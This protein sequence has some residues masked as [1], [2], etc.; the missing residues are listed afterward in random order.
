MGV[1][2]PA[3]AATPSAFD[4]YWYRSANEVGTVFG[5]VSPDSAMTLPAFY[6]AVSYVSE[7]IAK[8]PLSMYEDIGQKGSR[9]ARDHEIQELLHNQPN[10]RQTAIEWRENV[11]AIAMLRGS[12]IN[13]I[14]YGPSASFRGTPT[15]PGRI[16]EIVPLHPDLVRQEPLADGS[17]RYQYRDPLRNGKE[18][19][20]L[21][22]DTFIIRGRQSRGVLEYAA[23]N[24]G[25]EL[26]K[27][28][29]AGLMF[30]RGAKHSGVIEAKGKIVDTVRAGLRVALDEY[31]IGGPR[32]GRPL[33]LE[34]GMSWKDITM[35]AQQSDLLAMQQFSVSQVCRWI[36]VPPHK[37]FDLTRSTNNN[38]ETQGVDYVTD[39]LLAWAVRFEQAIWRDLVTD[40][41]FFAK[42]TLDGLLRGDFETRSKGYA[43]AIMWGWMTRNEVRAK[44]DYNPIEGL[45]EPLTPVNMTTDPNGGAA[46]VQFASQSVPLQLTASESGR[47]QLI[48]SDAA[49]RV[50]RRE[51][52]AMSKL[53]ERAA[54]DAE[55]WRS[56]VEAFYADHGPEVARQLHIPDHQAVAY[57]REQRAALIAGGLSAMDDWLV[58]R[59]G[60]LASLACDSNLPLPI[61]A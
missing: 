44:E 55:A 53:A 46:S 60:H 21:E 27:E 39:C 6:A 41:R 30:A 2:G 40:K 13:E 31:A 15:R 48:A 5:P 16:G 26:A 18:R 47:L 56:G 28:R 24:I 19:A 54:G 35:T 45:D 52:A 8:I 10:R 42:H 37:V 38:I 51:L 1:L 43:L 33:L 58:E 7:D 59:A 12:G 32:A 9:P 25:T 3:L 4:D 57:A 61:A 14:R 11:A 50:V 22:E 20:I 49:S 34:D 29:H 23:S 36:R 17:R